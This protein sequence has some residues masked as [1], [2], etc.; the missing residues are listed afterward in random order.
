MTARALA[1]HYAALVGSGVDG[2]RL[3]PVDRVREATTLQPDGLDV[4]LE[5]PVSLGLGYFLGQSDTA[6]SERTS[7]FGHPAFGGSIGFADPDYKFAFALLKNRLDFR[8]PA[9]STNILIARTVRSA[10]GIPEA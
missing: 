1:R 9:E 2:V 4:V 3:L 5:E 10:L 8:D 6:M 7:A